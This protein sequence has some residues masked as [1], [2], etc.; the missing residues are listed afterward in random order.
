MWNGRL[1]LGFVDVHNLQLQPR[2]WRINSPLLSSD[3]Q[4]R[5]WRK[6]AAERQRHVLWMVDLGEIDATAATECDSKLKDHHLAS[7]FLFFPSIS[8]Y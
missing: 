7:I 5:K 6:K 2:Q 1:A 3:K 8:L 4:N